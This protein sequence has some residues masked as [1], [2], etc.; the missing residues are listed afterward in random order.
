MQI[1][2]IDDNPTQPADPVVTR[3]VTIT[4]RRFKTSPDEYSVTVQ[5]P[6]FTLPGTPS[7]NNQAGT[8]NAVGPTWELKED[9][10]K[11]EI[12][13]ADV[14]DK[15]KMVIGEWVVLFAKDQRDGD[16]LKMVCQSAQCES[17]GYEKIYEDNVDWEWTIAGGSGTNGRFVS[18]P[19]GRYVVYEAPEKLQDKKDMIE[20]KVR[21][22]V[23]NA[24]ALKAT[25]VVPPDGEITLKI[26]RAGIKLDFPPLTWVPEGNNDV[27]V[28][29]YLVYKEGGTWK[30]ALA[31]QFRIHF[32]ELPK[33]SNERG[34]SMNEP[35]K[36]NSND[37][38]DLYLTN[39]QGHEAFNDK[40]LN[41]CPTKD[42]FSEART[43]KPEKEYMIVVKSADFGSYGLLKSEATIKDKKPEY[44]S[45]PVVLADFPHPVRGVIKRTAEKDNRV[46]IPRD[47][48]DNHIA[49]GGW[50]SVGNVQVPDPE[51]NDVDEDNTPVGDQFRGD[52]FTTYEEYRGFHT[53]T[54]GAAHVRLHPDRKDLFV[55]NPEAMPLNLFRQQSGL[56]VHDISEGQYINRNTRHVNFNFNPKMHKTNQLGIF[57]HNAVTHATLLGNTFPTVAPPNWVQKVELYTDRITT[58]CTAR[59]LN[60][61]EKLL[62]VTA[63][64]L[65]HACNVYHHGEGNP[66]IPATFNAVHG[67]R[68]GNISCIM[69]YDNVV[70]GQAETIGSI[71]CTSA[72]GTGTNANNQ[73]FGDANVRL[74][75]GNCLGQF[76]VSGMNAN[77]PRRVNANCRNN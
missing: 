4:T 13:L 14:P 2:I 8:C 57:L 30:P 19:K 37:C 46:S 59:G 26:F 73:N 12:Q 27:S 45:V 70:I 5:S 67:L 31:H 51:K 72:A 50:Q 33:V 54:T 39:E 34:T 21:V 71:F 24:D 18:D 62:Q 55:H 29:S 75:R 35:T 74:C 64:E 38:R 11:P 69:R 61:N 40:K 44:E 43:K 7:I 60:V 76:R 36:D 25:D 42:L 66:D 9:L 28:K 48:D 20:V 23:K 16:K 53:I 56:V 32:F 47:V 58:F 63:H 1:L 10:K 22:K 65:G 52:G 3:T 77:Y 49:D 6:P 15:D 17:S 68:S 41:N